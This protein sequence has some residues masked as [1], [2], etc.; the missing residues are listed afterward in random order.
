MY[1][2]LHRIAAVI[3]H[4]FIAE[5]NS[6]ELFVQGQRIHGFLPYSVLKNILRFSNP[7][8]ILRGILD[9]FLA[10]PFGQRSLIQRIMGITLNDDIQKMQ[11]DI[12]MLRE[13]IGDD[14]LC[15]K[16]K[17]YVDADIAIQDPI[18][19]EAAD[20][21]TELITAILRSEDI[22]PL[23]DGQQIVRTHAALDAWNS[24][25]DGV[26]PLVRQVSLYRKKFLLPPTWMLR[27]TEG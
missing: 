26:C 12:N 16:L 14:S 5:D 10:Q 24:A 8:G 2:N 1:A 20:G 7:I 3:Y 23:L 13:K 9:L 15:D 21:K 4:L 27:C 22:Q 25:V 11:K 17:N 18:R 19:Q 6:G